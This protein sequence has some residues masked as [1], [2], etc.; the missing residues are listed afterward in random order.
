MLCEGKTLVYTLVEVCNLHCMSI[1]FNKNCMHRKIH[2]MVKRLHLHT[3]GELD[4][5]SG[6]TIQ[7]QELRKS[8]C[9]E[10]LCPLVDF[11]SLSSL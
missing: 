11:H 8:G 5:T 7:S 2:H 4:M 9:L 10:V 1:E 6:L 3:K